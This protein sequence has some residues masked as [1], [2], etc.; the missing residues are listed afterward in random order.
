MLEILTLQGIGLNTTNP[1]PT[2]SLNALLSDR[3]PPFTLEKLLARILTSFE[4]L[5]GQ[6]IRTGF[7]RDLE[8]LYYQHWLHT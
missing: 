5:Y 1:A 4:E 8:E 7:S 6:F 2:T 3:I